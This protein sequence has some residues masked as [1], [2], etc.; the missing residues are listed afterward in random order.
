MKEC[1]IA[2][3]QA[4]ISKNQVL[5]KKHLAQAWKKASEF[6]LLKSPVELP[7]GLLDRLHVYLIAENLQSFQLTLRQHALEFSKGVDGS[8]HFWALNDGM[9]ALTD[10]MGSYWPYMTEA[11]R[12]QYLSDSTVFF[13]D[14][15]NY[16][17][18][19]T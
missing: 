5:I 17:A 2:Q 10:A 1:Q 9:S 6:L 4:F 19:P 16:E 7:E 8:A 13:A 3:S 15:P 14:L 12:M 11:R 18:N